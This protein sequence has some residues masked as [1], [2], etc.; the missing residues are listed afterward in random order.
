[1]LPVFD[2]SALS[3]PSFHD[4]AYDMFMSAYERQ[5]LVALAN[6]IAAKI[7]V[8]IGVQD[9]WTA[10]RLLADVPSIVNY[11]GVDVLPGYVPSLAV[12]RDEV[13]NRP[14]CL[15]ECDPRFFLFLRGRGSLD[16]SPNDLPRCDLMLIDGDHGRDAVV[17]DSTLARAAVR[18]GGLVIWHDYWLG[19]GICEVRDVL[20]EMHAAGC[21]LNRIEDTWFA[22]EE[23]Q[24]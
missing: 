19:D 15:V 17:H 5:V 7:V 10:R 3:L 4:P 21:A 9:G 11:I 23:K 6:S 2:T 8:E 12:Q 13:S 20:D 16:F 18:S 22:I 24:V 14:G 1:M